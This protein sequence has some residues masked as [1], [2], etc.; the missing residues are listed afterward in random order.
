MPMVVA[1]PGEENEVA[2][3]PEGAPAAMPP[4]V[5]DDV[6]DSDAKPDRDLKAEAVSVH[7]PNDTHAKEP[8]LRRM[9]T[10]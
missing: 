2:M 4:P 1:M 8:L 10:V 6:L 7:T 3:P 9:S 5:P